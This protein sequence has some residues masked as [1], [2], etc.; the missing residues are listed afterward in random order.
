M[1]EAI[2]EPD[3][4]IIDPHHHLW[5]LRPLVG[6][7]PEPLHPFIATVSEHPY[8]TFNEL[9]QHLTSG[10]NI[11][12][13]V[14]MECGA[15]YRAG[16]DEAMKVVGEVEYVNGVAAQGASGLYGNVRPC[17]AIIGHADLQLGDGVAEVLEALQ[18]AAPDR[19][20]GIRHQGAWD[21]D[22]DVLGPPFHAPEGLY[23]EA[24][25][26]EGFAHLGRMGLTF[27]AWILEPQL[28]DIIDLARAFPDQP[29]CLDH[30]GTPLGMGSYH[31]KLHERF[32]AW[33]HSIRELANCE[34]VV[35]KLGG[36]AMSFCGLPD[37]GPAAG[38]SSEDLAAMWRPYIETCIDAFGPQRAMFESNYPVDYWAADYPVLWN[39]FKRLTTGASGNDKRALYAGT[40]A[41]FYGIE[42]ILSH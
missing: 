18:A 26:R 2:L 42:H 3:L 19:F 7:F 27:D 10:H 30:C 25:F 14:F 41:K 33:R 36:L 28:G 21:A 1:T 17:A 22:P 9:H 23:R 4:P 24:D 12:G 38:T 15:F 32:D 11:V 39:A 29:I 8:Y 31:G 6:A 16:A 13:T 37:K 20:R 35:V 34:N 40:A 5:D